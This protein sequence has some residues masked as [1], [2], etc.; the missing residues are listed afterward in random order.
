[1][2]FVGLVIG[3]LVFLSSAS[4]EALPTPSFALS[5]A[6]QTESVPLTS[7]SDSANLKRMSK[8]F[9][10]VRKMTKRRARL[11]SLSLARYLAKDP[12]QDWDYY[13]AGSCK[14]LA[15]NEVRCIITVGERIYDP[16]DGSYL[17]DYYCA[18]N[19][20]SKYK[21]RSGRFKFRRIG[22]YECFRD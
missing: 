12:A 8:R 1:M 21:K 22:R 11:K 17:Y 15:R 9:R 2:V 19:T 10:S 3:S 14:R 18:A 13:G 4:A 20:L 5:E 6:A 16:N 7:Y